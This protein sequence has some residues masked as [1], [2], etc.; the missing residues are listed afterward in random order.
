MNNIKT[1]ST[2][3]L[4]CNS[5]QWGRKEDPRLLEWGHSSEPWSIGFWHLHDIISELDIKKHGI[6]CL[7]SASLI[8]S[9]S[10]C[11]I[12][13]R[14]S[15]EHSRNEVFACIDKMQICDQKYKE[16]KKVFITSYDLGIIQG[17]QLF[18]CLKILGERINIIYSNLCLFSRNICITFS[19]K[20][21]E[22]YLLI[23][24]LRAKGSGTGSL[25]MI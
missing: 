21:S 1:T 12:V 6:Q 23:V 10:A 16:K 18:I 7:L 24:I 20:S 5:N 8:A 13:S 17:V 14:S 19:H 2:S 9:V 22:K 4:S 25:W 3:Y 15:P 11:C